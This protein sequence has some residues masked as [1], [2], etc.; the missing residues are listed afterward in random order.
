M[1]GLGRGVPRD[2]QVALEWYQ[3]AAEQGDA[4]ARYNLAERYERGK[5]VSKDLVE[6]F[7][8]HSLAAEIG[9]QD[10]AK[11]KE[12]LRTQLTSEQI[13]EARKR[14]DAFKAKLTGEG[15]H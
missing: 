11:A 6:A 9:F 2:P 13:A 3:K 10:G 8:W 1:Y 12:N 7:K 14:I 4:L 5:D 15:T